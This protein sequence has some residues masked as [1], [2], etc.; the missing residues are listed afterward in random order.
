MPKKLDD[1]TPELY[2]RYK[3]TKLHDRH[4]ARLYGCATETLSAWKREHG[5]IGVNIQS[6]STWEKYFPEEIEKMKRKITKFYRKGWKR[7]AIAE[8]LGISRQSLTRFISR[9]LPHMKA[10]EVKVKLSKDQKEIIQKHGLT[11][12]TVLYRIH[13]G[14]PIE[15]ALTEQPIRKRKRRSKKDVS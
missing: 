10:Y 5:L 7:E 9:Y 6:W 2:L 14:W 13:A 12:N 1:L 11:A 8:E 4:I 3:R 15:R